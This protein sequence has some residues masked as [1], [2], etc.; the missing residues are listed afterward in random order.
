M[1]EQNFPGKFPRNFLEEVINVSQFVLDTEYERA[2][3]S[4]AEQYLLLT[5]LIA[6]TRALLD[7][8]PTHERVP[9]RFLRT[10]CCG[11]L[12][13]WVNPRF[14]TFCPSCGTNVYPEI[15]SCVLVSD[16]DA[17]LT[18]STKEEKNGDKS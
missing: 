13:C 12:L 5:D 1:T 4:D 2:N 15:R 3:D 8:S 16:H 17:V 7:A 18:F 14:P 9:F 10:P 6:R 11:H